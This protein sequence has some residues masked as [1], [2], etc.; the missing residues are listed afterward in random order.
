MKARELTQREFNKY[1]KIFNEYNNPGDAYMGALRLLG[2]YYGHLIY[3]MKGNESTAR[4]FKGA[5]NRS[6][7]AAVKSVMDD[8]DKYGLYEGK[9]ERDGG[10]V[11]ALLIG[12]QTKITESSVPLKPN[13]ELALRIRYIQQVSRVNIFEFAEANH[14]KVKK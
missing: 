2:D 7:I 5:W 8:H 11:E 9:S 4:F 14:P 1:T 13:G 3:W 12:L 6:H 10:T